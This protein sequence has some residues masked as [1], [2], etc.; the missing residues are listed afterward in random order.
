MRSSIQSFP[1]T[2]FT[3]ATRVGIALALQQ[4]ALMPS[5]QRNTVLG[6]GFVA[7]GLVLLSKG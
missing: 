3:P 4:I 1:V 7:L 6:V 2:T 5:R